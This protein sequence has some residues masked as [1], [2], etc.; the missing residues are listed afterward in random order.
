MAAG[1]TE[2]LYRVATA[3]FYGTLTQSFRRVEPQW[4]ATLAV[5][6]LLPVLTHGMEF[7][8]HWW[9]A[10][11]NLPASIAASVCLTLVS[12]TF[13]LYAM[14]RGVLVVGAGGQSLVSDLRALPSL[15]AG[16]ILAGPRFL[17]RSIGQWLVIS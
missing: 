9:R 3:G 11:P 1:W 8:V 15:I 4:Q 17:C 6:I 16:Y 5:L 7:A 2:F 13:N 12:T 10:T 14:R